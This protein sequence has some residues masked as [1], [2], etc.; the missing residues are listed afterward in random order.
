MSLT[1]V[2]NDA[3]CESI[4]LSGDVLEFK[5]AVSN[6]LKWRSWATCIVAEHGHLELLQYLHA[7]K[8]NWDIFVCFF[9]S[10]K[11]YFHILRWLHS[12]NLTDDNV[13]HCAM[14][15]N[16]MDIL[17]WALDN[18]LDWNGDTYALAKKTN[19]L[20]VIEWL[21]TRPGFVL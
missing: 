21:K 19:H 8:Y 1:D 15:H 16:Y 4:A 13:L 20:N 10:M 11:G 7:N 9:A 14:R 17:Q 18:N 5:K 12:V 3:L 6:G 2:E